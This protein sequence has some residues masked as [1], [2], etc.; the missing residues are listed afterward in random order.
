MNSICK[1][2]KCKHCIYGCK[3][4]KIREIPGTRHEENGII[5]Y[6]SP[7]SVHTCELYPDRY[8][9]WMEHF[10]VMHPSLIVPEDYDIFKQ[11]YEPDEFHKSLDNMIDLAQN[12]LDNIK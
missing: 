11:C 4:Y 3:H 12:I 6:D 1:K 5:W 10:G 2:A 9:D 8:S 7:K